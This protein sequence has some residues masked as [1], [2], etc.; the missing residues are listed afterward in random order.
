M[1]LP[2]RPGGLCQALQGILAMTERSGILDEALQIINVIPGELADAQNRLL[3]A[4][5]QANKYC[6]HI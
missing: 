3:A 5:I 2:Q 6:E 4:D 1:L